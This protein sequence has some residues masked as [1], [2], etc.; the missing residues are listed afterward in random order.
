MKALEKDRN[1]RYETANGLARD[2]ARYLAD[3]WSKPARL[4][5]WYRLSKW[6]RRN[7][8]MLTTASLVAL[9]LLLGLAVSV[10]QAL[11]AT[12][13][14]NSQGETLVELGKANVQTRLELGHAEEAEVKATQE[15]FDSL[16]AQAR[17]NRLSRRMGQRFG[18]L[19]IL[20]KAIGIANELKLPPGA[21]GTCERALAALAL[22]DLRVDKEWTGASDAAMDF[23]PGLRRYASGDFKGNVTVRSVG[24]GAEICRLP[25]PG[26][27]ETAPL[28][29]PDGRLL[30]VTHP[31]QGRVWVYRLGGEETSGDPQDFGGTGGSETGQGH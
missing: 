4:S 11:R 31:G 5:A 25:A 19:K 2:V 28:F 14:L 7:R 18:T 29:S 20:R 21:S 24:D 23:A 1:L 6:G 27:G 8:A 13:A 9:A 12:A 17:A 26:P 15:L 3:K 10:W 30:A 22:T 16:V